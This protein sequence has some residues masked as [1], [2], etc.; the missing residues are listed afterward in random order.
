MIVLTPVGS[1]LLEKAEE[2]RLAQIA[3][4][5]AQEE[6]RFEE[7]RKRYR[8]Q[9]PAASPVGTEPFL[10]VDDFSIISHLHHV[11]GLEFYASRAFTRAKRG[12]LV[13][14]TFAPIPGYQTYQEQRLGL[15]R[16]SYLQVPPAPDNLV[17]ATFAGILADEASQDAIVGHFGAEEGWWIHPYM[18]LE[19]SWEV[20]RTLAARGGREVKVLGPLPIVTECCNDKVWFA[21]VVRVV[22]GEEAALETVAGHGHEEIVGHLEEVARRTSR[23]SLKLADSATGMGTGIF[24]AQE[25]LAYSSDSLHAFVSDWLTQK[26]WE[27]G[28]RPIS[29]ERW[30]TD[31]LASPST[32]LWIPPLGEGAPWVEGVFDQLFYPGQDHVFLGSISSQLPAHLQEQLRET[33]LRLGRVFQHLGYLG[34]CS[35]DTILCGES[36]D[37][38]TLKYVECNGRWGGT[39]TP[40][41][42]MNR[43]FGDYRKQPYLAR[44][45]DDPCLKGVP[46]DRFA[47]TLDDILYNPGSQ[48]GWAIVYNVGCLQPAGKLDVITL[49][50]DFTQAAQ[51]QDEFRRLVEERF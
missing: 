8:E 41:S 27:V 12:D 7:E 32:Q 45:F 24:E 34:R 19:A 5:F 48:E 6:A 33:S 39:S 46:F 35:F 28:A 37:D 51:R 26:D 4:E 10:H 50:E 20:A 42:L 16:A 43:L 47:D 17:Y 25:L 11:L 36:L 38:A 18:G 31:V 22:L 3:R 49:G 1:G 29:I 40:M 15:G 14:G 23:V 13:A 30:Q 9:F 21:R 2:A 44:D